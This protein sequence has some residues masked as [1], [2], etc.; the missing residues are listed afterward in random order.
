MII[1]NP[2]KL[3][4][5]RMTW[6]QFLILKPF[7]KSLFKLNKSA[8]TKGHPFKL[9][10][11]VFEY[12]LSLCVCVCVCGVCVCVCVSVCARG[13]RVCVCVCGARAHACVC[14]CV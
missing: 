14:V 8:G 7:V 9:L 11:R 12:A 6:C 13:A 4:L 1:E 5:Y 3:K 10:R 2:V